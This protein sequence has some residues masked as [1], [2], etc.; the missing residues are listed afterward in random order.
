MRGA[1]VRLRVGGKAWEDVWRESW[2]CRV[3]M[4]EAVVFSEL[5]ITRLNMFLILRWRYVLDGLAK[6]GNCGKKS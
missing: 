1:G 2:S 6:I 4:C 5:S 3:W